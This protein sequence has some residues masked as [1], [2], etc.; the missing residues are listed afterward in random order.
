MIKIIQHNAE[1]K[2]L[3]HI[4]SLQNKAKGYYGLHFHLSKLSKRFKSPYQ[5]KISLNI[6]QNLFKDSKGFIFL[7]KDFDIM[8]VIYGEDKPIFEKAIFQ[9]RYLF[10]EDPLAYDKDG[11]ENDRFSQFYDLLFQWRDFFTV[12]QNKQLQ[13]KRTSKEQKIIQ[14]ARQSGDDDQILHPYHLA[15]LETDLK[16]VNITRCLRQQSVCALTSNNEYKPVFDEIYMSLLHLRQ[17]LIPSVD[18][19]S[20]RNLFKYITELL[21]IQMLN[22][23]RDRAKLYLNGSF[24]LNMNLSTLLSNAFLDFD[25]AIPSTSRKSIVIEIDIADVFADMSS[26]LM[27][28]SAIQALGYRICID[29]LDCHNILHLNR[30]QLGC[31]LGKIRWTGNFLSS[32]KLRK[33]IGQWGANRIVLCR[34]DSEEAIKTGQ[35]IGISLFQGRYVDS[36][37]DPRSRVKN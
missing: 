15:H 7:L 30:E 5:V 28:K 37:I 14:Q 8:V 24:S 20:N 25:A 10:M 3:T 16:N 4:E 6:L 27:A 12:C 26:Y 36:I 23:I 17:L 22:L 2:L 31:T 19:Y 9:L 29:N 33:A 18:I 13:D 11:S 1:S 32:N 35:S 21:D 34:C